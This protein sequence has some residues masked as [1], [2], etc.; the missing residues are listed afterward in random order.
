MRD[1]AVIGLLATTLTYI[2]VGQ[3]PG[4]SSA[5]LPASQTQPAPAK[6]D[7]RDLPGPPSTSSDED[8]N[9]YVVNRDVTAPEFLPA[10]LPLPE[11]GDCKKRLEG[12]VVLSF[13]VDA[14]G[15]PRSIAFEE[16]LGNGLDPL[17]YKILSADRFTPALHDG[18]PVK[19]PMVAELTLEACSNGP[20]LPVGDTQGVVK[21]NNQPKQKFR[22]MRPDQVEL[23]FAM[24]HRPPQSSLNGSELKKGSVTPPMAKNSVEAIYSDEARRKKIG[25]VCLV[26]LI[27]DTNGMPRN[28]RVRRPLGYGLDQ[29]AVEAARRYRFKPATKNGQPVPVMITVEINFRLY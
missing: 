18:A 21:L 23:E 7:S 12:T 16:G 27:V 22:A 28:V 17:A 19:V 13:L 26:S 25:G 6:S 20:P 4:T 9:I 5:P 10:E 29:N 11:T 2:A 3:Q 24:L 14:S 1:F 15:V 8:S